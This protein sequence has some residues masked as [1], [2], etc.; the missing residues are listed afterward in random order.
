M[1]LLPFSIKSTILLTENDCMFRDRDGTFNQHGFRLHCE[2]AMLFIYRSRGR[3]VGD[4]T[5]STT[6]ETSVSQNTTE[7]DFLFTKITD[8]E[9]TSEGQCCFLYRRQSRFEKEILNDFRKWLMYLLF[10]TDFYVC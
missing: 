1:T 7:G 2:M 4:R 10:I 5:A 8:V 9:Q 6:R 3:I